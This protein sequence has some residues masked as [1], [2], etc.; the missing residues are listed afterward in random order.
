MNEYAQAVE[1]ARKLLPEQVNLAIAPIKA[2]SDAEVAAIDAKARADLALAQ[3]RAARGGGG[4]GGGRGGG[5]GG[6][7][8][9]NA[10]EARAAMAQNAAQ[11]LGG[12]V[13]SAK[14]AGEKAGQSYSSL[15]QAPRAT[16]AER[17]PTSFREESDA[18]RAQMPTGT[19]A[20][21]DLWAIGQDTAQ[22]PSDLANAAYRGLGKAP[23]WSGAA[24]KLAQE[25]AARKRAFGGI[26]T[27]GGP[28]ITGLGGTVAAGMPDLSAMQT[29]TG[30]MGQRARGLSAAARL[31][32]QLNQWGTNVLPE[33]M[34]QGG[35]VLRTNEEYMRKAQM[36]NDPEAMRQAMIQQGLQMGLGEDVITA[37]TAGGTYT[38]GM[39]PA[40]FLNSITGETDR[41]KADETAADREDKLATRE[42]AALLKQLRAQDARTPSGAFDSGMTIGDVADISKVSEPAVKDILS[43]DRFADL[44]ATAQRKADDTAF[45]KWAREQKLPAALTRVL[46]ALR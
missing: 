17:A 41:T 37:A 24:Q 35:E 2:K 27:S 25:A 39:T 16:G 30:I 23:D 14:A 9:Y 32:G 6:K 38:P 7:T 43:D 26:I 29:G 28:N 1:S 21:S 19:L 45:K 4:G 46:D 13:Q 10:T 40:E 20:L 12:I 5:G 15:G 18:Y 22:S 42:E 31:A 36:L 3:A 44:M 11:Y 8:S 33:R 34:R